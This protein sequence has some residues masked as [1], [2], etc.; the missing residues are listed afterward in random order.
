MFQ[1]KRF[2]REHHFVAK[3][4]IRRPGFGGRAFEDGWNWFADRMASQ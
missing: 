4:V 2:K 1:Q 3:T